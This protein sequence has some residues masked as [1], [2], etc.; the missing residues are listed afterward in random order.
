MYSQSACDVGSGVRPYGRKGGVS[1]GRPTAAGGKPSTAEGRVRPGGNTSPTVGR[2]AAGGD[3]GGGGGGGGD[4]VGLERFS[5][6]SSEA[7]AE[8]GPGGDAGHE[9]TCGEDSR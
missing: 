3:G 4:D 9:D 1:S 8:G 2:G 6:A 5:G 7:E